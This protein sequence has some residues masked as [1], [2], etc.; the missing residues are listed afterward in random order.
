LQLFVTSR[1]EIGVMTAMMGLGVRGMQMMEALVKLTAG[2]QVE[3]ATM[4]V[5]SLLH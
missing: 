2:A 3:K 5:G 4:Q 1:L